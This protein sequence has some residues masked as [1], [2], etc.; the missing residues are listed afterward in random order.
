MTQAYWQA[1]KRAIP[2]MVGC[3]LAYWFVNGLVACAEVYAKRR[4]EWLAACESDGNKP[5]QCIER[6]E[7]MQGSGE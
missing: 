4:A 7:R 6:W 2:I 5:Y 3:F 1:L